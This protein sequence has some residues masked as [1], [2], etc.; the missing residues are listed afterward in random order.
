[1]PLSGVTQELRDVRDHR[2]PAMQVQQ[3]DFRENT[4]FLNLQ[5][6]RPPQLVWFPGERLKVQLGILLPP[7]VHKPPI[8]VISNNGS[9]Q[10]FR[11]VHSELQQGQYSLDWWFQLKFFNNICMDMRIYSPHYKMNSG[12]EEENRKMM[13]QDERCI[14]NI[15]YVKI[16]IYFTEMCSPVRVN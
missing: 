8:F 15:K 10:G 5:A 12:I 14:H 11:T 1:M 13:Q 9:A 6:F 3:R 2:L 7:L 16:F 4:A